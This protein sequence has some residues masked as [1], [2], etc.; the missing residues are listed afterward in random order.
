M[1]SGMRRTW[2]DLAAAIN[3]QV[4]PVVITAA[5]LGQMTLTKQEADTACA[6]LGLPGDAASLLAEIPYRGSIATMPP[7]DP[8]V[9]RF[10]E[11]VM[12]YGTRGKNSSRKSSVTAS[13]RPSISISF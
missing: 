13:C 3:P 5:L 4:S 9:Y 7:T 8:L 10:Y 12:V 2:K 11:L 1:P 6:L